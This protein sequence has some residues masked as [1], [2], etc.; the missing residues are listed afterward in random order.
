[1]TEAVIEMAYDMLAAGVAELERFDPTKESA[2][3]AVAR[4]Y[5][6]MEFM[7][8]LLQDSDVDPVDVGKLN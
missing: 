7:R 8:L 4:I 6:A 1:M 3:E 2:L 5:V